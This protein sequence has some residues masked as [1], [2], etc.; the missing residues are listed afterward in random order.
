MEKRDQTFQKVKNY[1]IENGMI[2]EGAV[3]IAAVSGGVD[4]MTMLDLLYWLREELNFSLR[5]VHVN[6]RIRGEEAERDSRLVDEFCKKNGI[7]YRSVERDVPFLA[8][9]WGIG[10]EEAGRI[11]RGEVFEEQR[12]IARGKVFE[13]QRRIARAEVF[14][15]QRRIA[16]AEVLAEKGRIA[17]SDV[18]GE[19]KE[20]VRKTGTEVRV[21]LAHNQNDQAETLLHHLARGTGLAGLAGI[22]P[23]SHDGVRIRPILCLTRNE[24]EVYAD[25][26]QIPCVTD[27]TNLEDHYTRNRIRHHI[28]PLLEEQ[29]NAKAVSHMADTAMQAAEAVDYLMEQASEILKKCSDIPIHINCDFCSKNV[30]KQAHQQTFTQNEAAD[31]ALHSISC[32]NDDIAE[33]FLG[34]PFMN[35]APV[36]RTYAVLCALEKLGGRRDVGA[37]HIRNVCSLVN[38]SRGTKIVLPNHRQAIRYPEGILLRMEIPTRMEPETEGQILSIDGVTFFHPTDCTN[39]F[40]FSTRI[41]TYSGENIDE[42]KCTKWFDYDKIE[43]TL[44]IRTRRLGDTMTINSDGQHKKLTRVMMD[45]GIPGDIR[46]EIPLLASGSEILWIIGG[47]MGHQYRIT[48]ETGRVIEIEYR[49]LPVPKSK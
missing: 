18:L 40:S 16:R 39:I 30:E 26:H 12:R 3:V 47:R 32:S 1:I 22:K 29:V 9:K 38:R 44:E 49:V 20:T 23:V 4:S 2:P 42:K 35:A 31:I 48:P 36:L 5:G 17:C 19:E 15:E 33:V 46:D 13:E 28:L 34:A 11:A 43:G 14:E 21:A 6:H 37:E 10:L 41:F 7:S 8:Q 27:S 25:Q 24:I 45:D